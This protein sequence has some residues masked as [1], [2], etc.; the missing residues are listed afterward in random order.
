MLARAEH[1]IRNLHV[2]HAVFRNEKFELRDEKLRTQIPETVLLRRHERLAFAERRLDI[3]E[4]ARKRTALP[5][6]QV[7]VRPALRIGTVERMPVMRA[8]LAWIH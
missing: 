6:I 5:R 7:G 3:A 8:V 1:L 4:I 2:P